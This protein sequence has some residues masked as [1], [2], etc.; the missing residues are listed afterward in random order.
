MYMY[1]RD[2]MYVDM[3]MIMSMYYI[4]ASFMFSVCRF[5]HQGVSITIFMFFNVSTT[6]RGPSTFNVTLT[7]WGPSS[8]K[9]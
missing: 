2:Y 5:P 3:Y 1:L 7:V 8:F 4:F 9:F 6:V